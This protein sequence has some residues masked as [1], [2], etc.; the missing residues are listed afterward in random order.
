MA[1]TLIAISFPLQL[2]R[3]KHYMCV[4]GG[5]NNAFNIFYLRLYCVTH[6]VRDYSER[7]PVAPTLATLS[8]QQYGVFY[9]HYPIERIAHI[10]AYVTPVVEH[11]L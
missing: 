1:K 3:S 8:N 6:V 2:R 11:W 10:M 7:K 9:R 5:G 4:W